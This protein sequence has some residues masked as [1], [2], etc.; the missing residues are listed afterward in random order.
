[1]ML[2]LRS[3]ASVMSLGLLITLTSARQ[4]ADGSPRS[5]REVCPLGTDAVDAA[6]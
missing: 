5:S 6:G 1:M 4:P 2:R 3:I